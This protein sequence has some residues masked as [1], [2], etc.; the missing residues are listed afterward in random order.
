MKAIEAAVTS[1]LQ[2]QRGQEEALAL[3]K[4]LWAAYELGGVEN[5]QAYL[6]GLRPPPGEDDGAAE[7]VEP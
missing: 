6:D 1:K 7:E 5:A 3:W 4:A 2:A